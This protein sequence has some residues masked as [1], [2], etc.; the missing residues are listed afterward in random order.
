MRIDK[1]ENGEEIFVTVEDEDEFNIVS[2]AYETLFSEYD[3]N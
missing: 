3:L 2:E 1:N